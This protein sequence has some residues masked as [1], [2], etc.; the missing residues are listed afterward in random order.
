MNHLNL[1]LTPW[2]MVLV[3]FTIAQRIF[4]LVISAVHRRRVLAMGA[5]EYGLRHFPFIVAVHVFFMLAIV[6]EVAFYHTHP[7]PMWPLWLALWVAAQAVRYA[8]IRALGDRWNVRVL[9]V[10]GMAPV[11]TGVYR[12]VRHPNYVAIVTEFIA[13]PMIFGAWRTAIVASALNAV[14]LAVRIRCENAALQRAAVASS[15]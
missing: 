1:H 5:V 4:E 6:F 2:P 12:W 15:R 8:A 9:V 11:R 13:A 7:G 10:P 14:A 3:G